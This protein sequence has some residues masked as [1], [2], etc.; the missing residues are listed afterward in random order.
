MFR[1]FKKYFRA[2]RVEAYRCIAVAYDLMCAEDRMEESPH[3]ERIVLETAYYLKK[4]QN[5][6]GI[7]DTDQFKNWITEHT[8]MIC[9]YY[10]N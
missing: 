3:K 9:R 5:A 10:N 8:D 1:R 6:I 2:N 4:A 7:D